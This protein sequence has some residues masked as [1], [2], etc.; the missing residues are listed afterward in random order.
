MIKIVKKIVKRIL[1][2]YRCSSN[3]FKKYLI[4]NG[5]KIGEGTYFFRPRTTNIDLKKLQYIE[6]GKYCKITDGVNILAHDYS[7]ITSSFAYKEL[8][9]RGGKKVVIGDNVFIGNRA[10][11]L[12]NVSIGDNVIIGANSVVTKDIPSNVVVAGNPAKI[13]CTLDNY[14][15]RLKKDLLKNCEYTAKVFFEKNGRIPKIE[16]TG[17]FMFAFLE[18]TKENIDKYIRRLEFLGNDFDDMIEIF[19]TTTPLF[20]GGIQNTIII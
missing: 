13:I 15:K 7:W 17:Y 9:P 11:I 18:R 20:G 6:I 16:E 8:F 4:K 3:A 10:T 19:M 14:H 5:C 2:S 12:C 1:F